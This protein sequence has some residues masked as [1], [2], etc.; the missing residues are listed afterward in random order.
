MKGVIFVNEQDN[1]MLDTINLLLQKIEKIANPDKTYSGIVTEVLQN[2]YYQVEMKDSI[3]K[4]KSGFT[5][6]VGER[7]NVLF[8]QSNKNNLYLYP[9]K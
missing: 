5:Y 2:G 7:V 4:I 1:I 6:T 8:I 9:N 3:H